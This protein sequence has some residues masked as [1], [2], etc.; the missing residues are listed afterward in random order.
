[1]KELKTSEEWQK[2]CKFLVTDPDGW[3]RR[4][5]KFNYSWN[6][7]KISRNKFEKRLMNSTLI[8]KSNIPMKMDDDLWMD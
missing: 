3:D 1:M 4:A 5:E 6:K 2:I 8:L 7:E